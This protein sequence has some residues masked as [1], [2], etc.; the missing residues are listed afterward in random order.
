MIV[1]YAC[2][3]VF[4]CKGTLDRA[5]AG[6]SVL[7]ITGPSCSGACFRTVDR[8]G[9]Q[10]PLRQACSATGLR[11]DPTRAPALASG[12]ASILCAIPCPLP[13]VFAQRENR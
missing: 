13:E 1:S 11:L 2:R 6:F 10:S 4:G 7:I 12:T 5:A 3:S 8:Y 9:W